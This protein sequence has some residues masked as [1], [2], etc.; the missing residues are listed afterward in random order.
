[1]TRSHWAGLVLAG[2]LLAGCGESASES[3]AEKEA[4]MESAA[5]TLPSTT[6]PPESAPATVAPTTVPTTTAAPTTTT[7]PTTTT[8][9]PPPPPAP[10]SLMPAV[11]C[12]NLQEAQDAIQR[13]GVFFSQSFDA[14]GQ[15]RMQLVDSNWVVVS[16]D[17]PPGTPITEGQANL[18]AVKYGEP[19]AC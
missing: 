16:Q 13:T 15:G 1:M 7:V 8:T 6:A 12:M 2:L 5:L 19:G 9:A 3:S 14:T 17:P 18:G 10:A 4:R 11:V